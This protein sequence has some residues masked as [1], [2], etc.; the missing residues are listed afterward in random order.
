M[1][2][3]DGKFC[4]NCF[5]GV[6]QVNLP[7][8]RGRTILTDRTTLMILQPR[9]RLMTRVTLQPR[10]VTAAKPGENSMVSVQED[11]GSGPSK[12]DYPKC[13]QK[14]RHRIVFRHFRHF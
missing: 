1:S 13:S 11:G 10:A 7:P 3:K 14:Y 4:Q 9:A 5:A 12:Q 2:N 8:G 6:L